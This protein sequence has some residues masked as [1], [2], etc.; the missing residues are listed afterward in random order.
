MENRAWKV[1]VSFILFH[2]ALFFLCYCK[3]KKYWKHSYT[4]IAL[5]ILCVPLL[6]EQ[7]LPEYYYGMDH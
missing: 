4:G 6:S 5:E 1:D 2:T 7:C 3:K